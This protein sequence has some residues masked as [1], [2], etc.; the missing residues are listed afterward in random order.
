MGSDDDEIIQM[1]VSRVFFGA[2]ACLEVTMSSTTRGKTESC[3]LRV[4]I[5]AY[6]PHDRRAELESMKYSKLREAAMQAGFD[7]EII[8]NAE[9]E[10]ENSKR[11]S[12]S[13]IEMILGVEKASA[14]PLAGTLRLQL[15]SKVRWIKRGL[16]SG[17]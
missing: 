15:E 1:V 11:A 8:D 13:L 3:L 17:I 12:A 7:E 16:S 4:N 6:E 10:A 14:S 2:L 9:D 5:F